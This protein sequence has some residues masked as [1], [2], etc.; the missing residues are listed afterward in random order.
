MWPQ[1]RDF[2]EAFK[3]R[4]FTAVA[5][6]LWCSSLRCSAQTCTPDVL[7]QYPS[8]WPALLDF[9][10]YWFGYG[11]QFEKA[12]PGKP[13]LHYDPVKPTVIYFHGWA[14]DNGGT[15]ARCKRQTSRCPPDIC[16]AAE[17]NLLLAD[18]WLK[19]GWN[20]GFF[21][22][23]Q[24]SDEECTRD[25]EQKVWFDKNG[26][27]LRW[28]SYNVGS[29]V[30]VYKQMN[31]TGTDDSFAAI[32]ARA[33]KEVM[34]NFQG[35]HV[36]FVGHSI[37][38]QLAVQTAS[39]LW[40]EAHPASPRR[41]ALL[42]P[43]FTKH[44]LY[45]FRCKEIKTDAGVG[46]F[47]ATATAETVKSL[48]ET[49]QVVTEVYKS[50]VLTQK[51]AFGYPAEEL[52]HLATLVIYTPRWCGDGGTGALAVAGQMVGQMVGQTPG[53]MPHL[54]CYHD[55]VFPAYF[56]QFGLSPGKLNPPSPQNDALPG[57]ALASCSTPS[58]A[59]NDLQIRQWVERQ[60]AGDVDGSQR[61]DQ[62]TGMATFNLTDDTF[63]LTPSL[64]R[65]SE[66]V[67][68]DP[69]ALYGKEPGPPVGGLYGSAKRFADRAQKRMT[70][71]PATS[72]E[73]GALAGGLLVAAFLCGCLCI[74][75]A[76]RTRKSD[77]DSMS[78]Y[79][80]SVEDMTNGSYKFGGSAYTDSNRAPDDAMPLTSDERNSHRA[81]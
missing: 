14:G 67:G 9:G 43:F 18:P 31:G 23:D 48:W 42:E 70:W 50:S 54:R 19:K 60:Q 20:V 58:S 64:L 39:L 46:G 11:D 3:A 40:N 62:V 8:G 2:D 27:G 1:R 51:E 57:S 22:W 5:S 38:A 15:V 63:E 55:A 66:R 44:H 81:I 45:F 26:N 21:Y 25:A 10:I 34:H 30:A 41:L 32:S 53:E 52:S 4:F 49:R 78:E 12:Y 72:V 79:E 77:D 37:G 16:P 35:P 28:K 56:L 17:G 29:M 33:I 7:S 61:W 80:S 74:M 73:N 68:M 76:C 59:C 69:V 24:L 6:A 36:R 13:N 75:V 47:T 71:L 65:V